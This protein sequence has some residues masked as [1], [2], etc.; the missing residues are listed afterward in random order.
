MAVVDV[1]HLALDDTDAFNRFAILNDDERARALRF[2][3][4]RDR[5]RYVARRAMLREILASYLGR[6]P[7]QVEFTPNEFGK[8]SIAGSDLRFNL[9]HSHGVALYAIA[10]GFEVGCDIE[11]RDVGF[12]D[13]QIP[14][15]FFSPKEV[16][17]LR[18]L[19]PE[20]QTEGFFNCWTRKEAYIK[21]R[22]YGL[23]LPLDSFDVSLAPGAPAAL[24]RSCDGWS[25][26]SFEP[27][28]GF[29]AAVVVEGYDWEMRL[30]GEAPPRRM[31]TA[32]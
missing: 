29:Q 22:G 11:R 24:Q 25:V 6:A 26:K 7:E 5:D 10:R 15:H 32:A 27:L 19:P 31:N 21:A 30:L 20:Q 4:A 2:R 18:A 12:A 8:L 28:P 3:H 17:A 14:E 13:D 16:R 9:S 1:Y 23:S